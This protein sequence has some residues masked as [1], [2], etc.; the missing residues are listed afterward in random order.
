VLRP[1]ERDLVAVRQP[2]DPDLQEVRGLL[3]R[4]KLTGGTSR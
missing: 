3:T 1:L 2:H 4:I